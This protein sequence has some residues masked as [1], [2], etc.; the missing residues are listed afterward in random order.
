MRRLAI[1][2]AVLALL[3]GA[4]PVPAQDRAG[5][6]PVV[7]SA[8]PFIGPEGDEAARLTVVEIIDPFDGYDAVYPPDRGTHYVMV[9]FDIENA[10]ARPLP[11]DPSTFA[12][13]DAEG[14]LAFP[15]SISLLPDVEA[16]SPL[17]GYGEIEAGGALSGSVVFAVFNG[18]DPIRILYQ[19]SR[20]RLLVLADLRESGAAGDAGSA[21]TVPTEAPAPTVEPI[22]PE[23]PAVAGT[24]P[25]LVPTAEPVAPGLPGTDEQ[26]ETPTAGGFNPNPTPAD[27]P[28][29]RETFAVL[30]VA[31][32]CPID[33]PLPD[34]QVTPC[35]PTDE[36]Y[37]V[38]LVGDNAVLT[39]DDLVT[40]QAGTGWAAVPPGEYLLS[41]ESLP[42]GHDAY[43]V[44]GDGAE[45]DARVLGEGGIPV[46][47]GPD[48]ANA[49]GIQTIQVFF[50]DSE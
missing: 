37:A 43:F 47:V 14:F 32:N 28:V 8:V 15:E 31:N 46:T 23:L 26:A 27:E 9:R 39:T 30:L 13:Q 41:F 40:R 3:A 21:N 50:V 1:V 22:A 44:F 48:T 5:A 24:E 4:V 7:G 42:E 25:T 18:S 29:A 20:D 45:P 12:I 38:T 33:T 16:Q 49:S 6:D 2:F 36:G 17:L 11:V 35:P 19:P 10:G 34:I